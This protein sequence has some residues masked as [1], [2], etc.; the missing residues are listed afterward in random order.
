MTRKERL[1]GVKEIMAGIKGPVTYRGLKRAL[2][3]EKIPRFARKRILGEVK[4]FGVLEKAPKIPPKPFEKPGARPTPKEVVPAAPG[5]KKPEWM[6]E[7]GR[8]GVKFEKKRPA[9][10]VPKFREEAKMAEPP[11]ERP[12]IAG[13]IPQ[14]S[15]PEKRETE[16]IYLEEK[17]K[18]TEKEAR[19]QKEIERF[20]AL[21]KMHEEE[22]ERIG[23]QLEEKFGSQSPTE[24]QEEK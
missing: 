17:K 5:I 11:P 21:D 18:A 14:K 1:K 9:P 12:K 24:S 20:H 22:E 8:L 10:A 2:A 16:E 15:L 3:E 13:V 7:T 6:E 19:R 23:K 4:G